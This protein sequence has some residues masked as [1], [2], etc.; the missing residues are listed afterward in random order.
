MGEICEGW[1][2]GVTRWGSRVHSTDMS[3]TDGA[4]AAE[5]AAQLGMLAEVL[6]A[7]QRR[8]REARVQRRD[9]IGLLERQRAAYGQVQC[10]YG[11]GVEEG[12]GGSP[13]ATHPCPVPLHQALE[14]CRGLLC[15]LAQEYRLGT[16][17]ELDQSNAQYLETKCSA[18][19]LKAR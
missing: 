14:Q 4:G 2:V 7:E 13:S 15:Q 18:M 5:R 12:L 19:L 16:Q 9:L 3:P 8:L 11:Y 1:V 10:R 17:A 6:A